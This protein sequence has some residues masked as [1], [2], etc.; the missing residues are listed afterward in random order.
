MSRK[1][2]YFN[3]SYASG[4]P[5][6]DIIFGSNL[7]TWINLETSTITDDGAG[8][9]INATD[10]TGNGNDLQGG[11]VGYRPSINATGLNS[12]RTITF[13]GVSEEA[14][15]SLL[16]EKY[17]FLHDGSDA[18]VMMLFKIIP[19]NPDAKYPLINT[20]LQS[21]TEIGYA[22]TF[23]DRS[24]LSRDER[25]FSIINNGSGVDRASDNR[26]SDNYLATQQWVAIT[27][28]I[29]SDNGTASDRS[30]LRLDN[31]SSVTNNVDTGTPSS[32]DASNFLKIGYE[33]SGGSRVYS[34][35]EL[36]ELIIVDGA[37]TPT[38]L[39]QLQTYL[40]DFWGSY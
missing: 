31:S 28:V 36:A 24:S 38:Q 22:L 17:T 20:C 5:T 6:P 29:D 18:F 33:G 30:N 1:V 23:D 37:V 12:K 19:A 3:S 9:F 26:T 7:N 34:N 13:D 4:I 27:D 35:I 2:T 15:I 32:S 25:V 39:T 11:S 21:D 16:D 14:V 10:L 8:N 40:N